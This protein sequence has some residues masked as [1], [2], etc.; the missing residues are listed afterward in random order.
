VNTPIAGK[1]TFD[2]LRSL[3]RTQPQERCELCAAPL[4]G[5][6]PH[7]LESSNGRIL[8]SC[9]PCA[10]LFSYREE[11][12][13]FLRLPSD[14]RK[15][16]NFRISDADWSALLLP[17]DIAFFLNRSDVGRVIAYYPSPA[18]NTESLLS[19]DHWEDLVRNNPALSR[20]QPD[21]EALLVNRTRGRR[22]YYIA[23]L[24][25]CYRLTG[26]IR[27]HWR[28]LSGG[29]VVWEEIQRFFEALEQRSVPERAPAHA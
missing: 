21:I 6:H 24:D 3:R 28:G 9:D 26:L 17:I 5:R 7:L 16:T 19:L 29:D 18:G 27:M 11:G 13:K 4:G 1:K 2:V 23:P 8:C 15:L 14:P 25:E 20:M 12:R 10:I 22:D